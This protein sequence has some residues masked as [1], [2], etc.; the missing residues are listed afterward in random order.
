MGRAADDMV[1]NLMELGVIVK[2]LGIKQVADKA[3]LKERVVKKFVTDVMS[4]K[5]GDISKINNAVKALKAEQDTTTKES[6]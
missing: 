3:G 6:E 4:A 1:N 5:G 2:K